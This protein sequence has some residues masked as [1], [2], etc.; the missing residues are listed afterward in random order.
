MRKFLLI[1]LLI[2]TNNLFSQVILIKDSLLNSSIENANLTF[3]TKGV[4]SDKNGR[5]DISFFN[6]DDII[7]ISH[8]SY[9]LKK[10][11]KKNTDSIIYLQQK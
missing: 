7:E 11:K 4:T 8:V 2:F 10:I 9:Y 1:F 3:N 6:S 5:V